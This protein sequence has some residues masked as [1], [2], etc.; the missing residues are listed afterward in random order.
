MKDLPIWVTE[1]AT[2]DEGTKG[3]F[4]TSTEAVLKRLPLDTLRAS[5]GATC[6]SIV[7]L[8]NRHF[9]FDGR[10]NNIPQA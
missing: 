9:P 10:R 4:S 6:Q 5:L 2:K 8:L 1:L 3:F 7:T